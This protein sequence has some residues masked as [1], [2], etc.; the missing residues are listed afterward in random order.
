MFAYLWWGG[1]KKVEERYL[2]IPGSLS[3]TSIQ[4]RDLLVYRLRKLPA[5]LFFL[6]RNYHLHNGKLA[7]YIY[8]L[9]RRRV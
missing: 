8:T 3:E 7:Q 6:R 4:L 9:G 2:A 1:W 5:K